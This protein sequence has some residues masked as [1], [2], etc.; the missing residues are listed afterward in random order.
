MY[1]CIR[2]TSS[3]GRPDFVSEVQ[4]LAFLCTKFCFI[5]IFQLRS[6]AAL[7]VDRG[8]SVDLLLQQRF[9]FV[10]LINE[11]IYL[12]STPFFPDRFSLW[13]AVPRRCMNRSSNYFSSSFLFISDD[14]STFSRGILSE[15]TPLLEFPIF[16]CV[17]SPISEELSGTPIS[18]DPELRLPYRDVPFV[19]VFRFLL[20]LR[21]ST[22]PPSRSRR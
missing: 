20:G 9:I 11:L 8:D 19:S 17:V 3:N 16:T 4:S 13:H 10:Q 1:T 22:C 18:T 6:V 5:S 7:T 12:P 15:M 14:R 2:A 21:F